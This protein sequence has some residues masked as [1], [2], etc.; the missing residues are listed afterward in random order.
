MERGGLRGEKR[1]KEGERELG[2]GLDLIT[3]WNGWEG[4]RWSAFSIVHSYVRA[5]AGSAAPLRPLPEGLSKK[6]KKGRKKREKTKDVVRTN[7]L[8]GLTF[9]GL[10]LNSRIEDESFTHPVPASIILEHSFNRP[11]VLYEAC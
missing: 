6:K 7:S 4:L 2:G 9:S 10:L 5:E 1:K 8:S 3:G 11:P